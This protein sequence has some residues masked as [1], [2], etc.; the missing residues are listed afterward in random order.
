M[1]R[2]QKVAA[3]G[4]LVSGFP[5]ILFAAVAYKAAFHED[6]PVRFPVAMIAAAVCLVFTRRAIYCSRWYLGEWCRAGD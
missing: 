6:D 3:F 5:A 2:S 1:N 4:A